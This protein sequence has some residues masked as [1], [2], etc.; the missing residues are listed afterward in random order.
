MEKFVRDRIAQEI[1]N[2]D[3]SYPALARR[4]HVSR[5]TITN[6]AR[7]YNIVR[8]TPITMESVGLDP[9]VEGPC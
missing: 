8:Q 1:E 3:E 9:L 7:E 4:C 2:S 6:I 5:S